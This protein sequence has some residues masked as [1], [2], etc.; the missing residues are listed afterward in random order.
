MPPTPIADN[1]KQYD[2]RERIVA[3]LRLA[4]LSVDGASV[5]VVANLI[6]THPDDVLL[7]TCR[8]RNIV[9]AH[10]LRT[11]GAGVDVLV[12]LGAALTHLD[13]SV[14]T[15]MTKRARAT[16]TVHVE[17][18]GSIA[19]A[20]AL[21]VMHAVQYDSDFTTIAEWARRE[22][23]S[24]TSLSERA[25]MLGIRPKDSR[26]FTRMFRACS[27]AAS[28][29]ISIRALL[30]V[31]D[32]RTLAHL[33]EKSGLPARRAVEC[34]TATAFLGSQRFIP[35]GNPGLVALTVR[36]Q[37]DATLREIFR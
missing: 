23:M 34:D 13:G 20:W 15:T 16:S 26:D 18:A 33:I 21:N 12:A 30:R 17:G 35:Q 24:Y 28:G 11:D 22:G 3:G 5:D 29:R 19:D 4:G 31:A 10:R 14:A 7:L 8:A 6:K 37:Q 25:R 27:R 9:A 1:D 2:I 32:A 36:V